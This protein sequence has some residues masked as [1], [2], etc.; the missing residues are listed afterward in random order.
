MEGLKGWFD[1]KTKQDIY[2][3]K[4]DYKHNCNNVQTNR[5]MPYAIFKLSFSA[6]F[7]CA[8]VKII[9]VNSVPLAK[10]VFLMKRIKAKRSRIK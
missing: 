6:S 5:Y 2:E 10:M 4:L 9:E 3:N 7:C 8:L 1:H